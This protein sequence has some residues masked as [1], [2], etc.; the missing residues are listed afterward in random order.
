MYRGICYLG[1]Q[2]IL[3]SKLPS[4][5]KIRGWVPRLR[6]GVCAPLTVG[7]YGSYGGW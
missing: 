5:F 1:N 7:M 6:S 4:K 2:I 3:P